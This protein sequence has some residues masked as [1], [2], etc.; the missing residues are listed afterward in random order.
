MMVIPLMVLAD[1]PGGIRVAKF[2]GDRA[3]AISFTFDDNMRDQ[4][5]F[6]VPMLA[7]YGFHGTFFIVAGVTPDTNE[8]TAKKKAGAHGSIS[9]QRL[10]ELEAQGHEMANH[11]WTHAN[12]PK[13]DDAKLEEEVM[14]AYRRIAEKIGVAPV[15]FCYPGNGRDERVRNF[16]LRDHI[17][18]RDTQIGYGGSNFTTGQ[19]NMRIDDAIKKGLAVV[20]MI[21]GITTGYQPFTSP[22]VFENHLKYVKSRED[23]IWVDTF[24]N[25]SRYT[26]ER[27][28][29]KLTQ[30]MTEKDATFTLKCSLDQ[31]KFNYPLTVVIPV[32]GAAKVEAKRRDS[33][34]SLPVEVRADCILVQ[35]VPSSQ[36]VV[37][38][39]QAGEK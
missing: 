4:D 12:L 35:A 10:K 11:S 9:W 32:K 29:V 7:K 15:T 13:S 3:A 34:E 20:G 21:H 5:E 38:T 39:W 30:A 37:V 28:A 27:D 19:V 1:E 17:A 16:V 2:K 33:G 24:A 18:A 26:L 6:A 25:V 14:K 23:V 36:H 22:D 8:E 31:N